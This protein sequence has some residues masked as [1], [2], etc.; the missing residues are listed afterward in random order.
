M[1]GFKRVYY[2]TLKQVYSEAL[3][4]GVKVVWRRHP[5]NLVAKDQRGMSKVGMDCYY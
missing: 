2:L 1:E 3:E 5:A 4:L